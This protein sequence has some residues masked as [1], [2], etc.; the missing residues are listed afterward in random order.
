ME[1]LVVKENININIKD[2]IYEVRGKEVMLDSDLAKLYQ[3]KN[4]T[5]DIN[6]AVSRNRNKFPNDFCFEI[7]EQEYD[8]I[9]KIPLRFQ[10]GTSKSEVN[11]EFKESR[12]GR[13]YNINVFTEE[14]VAM[15]ATVIHTPVAAEVS[16]NIMRAFVAMRHFIVENKDVLKNIVKIKNNIIDIDNKLEEHDKNFEIVFSKFNNKENF[17]NK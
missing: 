15:L 11:T 3:C 7:T 6:K 1:G 2:L 9:S 14:G 13:R 5:K 10:N 8:K 4:G 16:V 12:G 17:K